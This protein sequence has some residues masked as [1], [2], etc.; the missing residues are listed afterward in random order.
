MQ[1]G[2]LKRRQFIALLGGATAWPLVARAQQGALPVVAA[3][4][5]I[6]IVFVGGSD[7]IRSGHRAA[8]A[9]PS[10]M[11][12]LLRSFGYCDT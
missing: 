10:A 6:P 3:T 1:F 11:C 12:E 5:T 2:Q 4:R 7:P 9:A 8:F